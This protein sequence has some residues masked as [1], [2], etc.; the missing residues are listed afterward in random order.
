[1]DVCGLNNVSGYSARQEWDGSSHAD[2]RDAHEKHGAGKG[3]HDYQDWRGKAPAP[4]EIINER[5]NVRKVEA[6]QRD[7]G[8]QKRVCLEMVFDAQ[9]KPA[10]QIVTE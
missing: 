4:G 5:K 3:L 9:R 2:G 10:A 6:P 1:M 7:D 8:L